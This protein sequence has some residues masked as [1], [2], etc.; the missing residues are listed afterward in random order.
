MLVFEKSAIFIHSFNFKKQPLVYVFC[1]C[2]YLVDKNQPRAIPKLSPSKYNY[3]PS[4]LSFYQLP[5]SCFPTFQYRDWSQNFVYRYQRKKSGDA[6]K[7]KIRWKWTG[8]TPGVMK[9]KGVSSVPL[10]P[11][12]FES[13]CFFCSRGTRKGIKLADLAF[14]PPFLFRLVRFTLNIKPGSETSP[15]HPLWTLWCVITLTK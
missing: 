7:R 15:L 13:I 5:T 10:R 3:Y 4:T 14:D 9:T 1:R 6:L 11:K 12:L 2:V 8:V